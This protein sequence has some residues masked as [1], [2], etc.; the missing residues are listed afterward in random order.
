MDT[1]SWSEFEKVE[2]RVGTVLEVE[3]FLKAKKSAYLLKVD[4]GP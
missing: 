2:L 3:D 4:Y 1:I